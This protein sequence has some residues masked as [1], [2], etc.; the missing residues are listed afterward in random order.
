M[1]WIRIS[2]IRRKYEHGASE[3]LRGWNL[4]LA[5][6]D[7]L[8]TLSVSE[9]MTQSELARQLIVTQGNIT[10]LLDK[11]EQRGLLLRRQEG[12]RKC[13]MLT[14][15]GRELLKTVV[16]AHAL[17]NEK[18]FAGLSTEEQRELL[19]L[20]RKLDHALE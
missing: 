9:G 1:V 7:L 20:L 2:R 14:E 19:R 8:T 3:E 15:R 12:R 6:F 16:P 13:L 11:L 10:Q 17:W 5:L 4:S 18:Q